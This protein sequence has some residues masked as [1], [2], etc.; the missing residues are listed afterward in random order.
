MSKNSENHINAPSDYNGKFDI[1]CSDGCYFYLVCENTN[2]ISVVKENN[3]FIKHIM[4]PF[5]IYRMTYDSIN[6]VFICI[7]S[8]DNKNIII[9]NKKGDV[10]A[11]LDISEYIDGHCVDI[12]FDEKKNSIVILNQK[13]KVYFI[14]KNG[15]LI[16]CEK[17]SDI[18]CIKGIEVCNG[19]LFVYSKGKV[20]VYDFCHGVMGFVNLSNCISKAFI[21]DKIDDCTYNI[22]I[23]TGNMCSI[24]LKKYT[25]TIRCKQDSCNSYDYCDCNFRGCEGVECDSLKPSKGNCRSVYDVI[26]SIALQEAG[27]SHIINAEGEKI[28]KAIAICKSCDD[29]IRVNESVKGTLG[30]VI[31]CEIML[32]SKLK[33]AQEIIEKL[34]MKCCEMKPHHCK[35]HHDDHCHD[36]FCD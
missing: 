34:D 14:D 26:E 17:I 36:N 3:D 16:K 21:I 29:L 4:V 2:C 24:N 6:K 9:I 8:S 12:A 10:C 30:K 25:L 22:F 11:N 7:C 20:Q 19:H 13:N 5:G 28:Q 32:N 1:V 35:D 31:E 18:A 15:Y 23:V 33:T 27:I